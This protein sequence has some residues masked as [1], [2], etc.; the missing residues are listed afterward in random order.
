[1]NRIIANL[2][3]YRNIVCILS[4][5]GI[6]YLLGT[7]RADLAISSNCITP[8]IAKVA[9]SASP[10]RTSAPHSAFEAPVSLNSASAAAA[11]QRDA[12]ALRQGA[13]EI[14]STLLHSFAGNF[15]A[16]F[17]QDAILYYNFFAG[18]LAEGRRGVYVDVGANHPRELSNTW[19]MDRCLGWTGV[20]IEADP[21]NAAAFRRS[22]RTCTVVNMC[23]DSQRSQV[24][25]V[26][27]GTH[28]H[29][30]GPEEKG[31]NTIKCAPLSAILE[32]QGVTHVD[33]LSIDIEGAE[34][35]ALAGNDWDAVPV[36]VL[37]TESVWSNEQ[38]DM[39]L[40]DAGF[41]RVSDI[42]YND[43]VY[44]RVRPLLKFRTEGA[45]RKLNWDYAVRED[46]KY[47]RCTKRKPPTLQLDADGQVVYQ[48]AL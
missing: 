39:L 17:G 7:L 30:A 20:C 24:S 33:F 46:A 31:G 14:C 35:S 23:V 48:T 26:S 25:F 43:D 34:V 28:S 19:F 13:P 36:S 38:L 5:C 27:A 44:V 37:L 29:V 6:S 42:G 4:A 3:R 8:V 16:Q 1:M 12:A 21:K 32:A 45:N 11:A 10:T 9:A 41:W 2:F 40:H 22:N 18:W 15:A 47:K